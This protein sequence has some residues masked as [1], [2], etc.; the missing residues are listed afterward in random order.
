MLF[1]FACRIAFPWAA[2]WRE[3]FDFLA[4][5]ERPS[6]NRLPA[7]AS[8]PCCHEAVP[9]SAAAQHPARVHSTLHC[10][11]LCCARCAP[12]CTRREADSAA[13]ASAVGRDSAL[14]A[15]QGRSWQTTRAERAGGA[16]TCTHSHPPRQPC[17]QT[18]ALLYVAATG[19]A[20]NRQ[21]AEHPDSAPLRQG[22]A[23][24]QAKT[25][26]EEDSGRE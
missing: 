12:W 3:H 8:L 7:P 1:L 21:G 14:I 13:V 23:A 10:S 17:A 9:S 18:G 20:E 26:Q 4:C 5:T 22:G 6:S 24:C 19:A 16:A 15:A 2:Q 11:F 25:R